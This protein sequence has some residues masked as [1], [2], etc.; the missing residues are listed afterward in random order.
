[1]ISSQIISTA[2]LKIVFKI[3]ADGT[4]LRQVA[5]GKVTHLKIFLPD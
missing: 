2:K 3:K 5:Q 4:V 1:M